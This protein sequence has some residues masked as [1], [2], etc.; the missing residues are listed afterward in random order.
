MGDDDDG[1]DSFDGSDDDDDDAADGGDKAD[2]D[3]LKGFEQ[4]ELKQMRQRSFWVKKVKKKKEKKV[5][6]IKTKPKKEQKAKP[7]DE[8]KEKKEKEDGKK[9]KKSKEIVHK[10]GISKVRDMFNYVLQNKGRSTVNREEIVMR[11]ES[12]IVQCELYE[13][14]QSLLTCISL[15]VSL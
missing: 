9:E 11:L 7:G 6:K 12:L 1:G 2:D 3:W 4:E 15:L 8:D 10:W 13:A 5:K 14:D